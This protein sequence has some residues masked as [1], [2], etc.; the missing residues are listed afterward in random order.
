MKICPVGAI[1]QDSEGFPVVD[2]DL[3]IECEECVNNCP[4]KAMKNIEE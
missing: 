4:K 2:Y 3:C 1:T